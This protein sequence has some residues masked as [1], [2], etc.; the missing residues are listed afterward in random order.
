MVETMHEGTQCMLMRAGTSKGAFFTAEDLPRDP[1][2]RDDLLLRIMG[3][4]D[5]RQIDGIGSG[6]PQTSKV[7]VISPSTDTRAD[8]D[9]LFLQVAVDQ[10]K[11]TSR[12]NCG[13]VL[14]GVGPFAVER[15]LVVPTEDDVTIRIRMVNSGSF[16]K[17]RFAAPN[18]K[19]RYEGNHAIDSVPGTAAPVT[20][21]FEDTAGSTTGALLPTGNAIDTAAG[22]QVTCVDNGMPV[23][24]VKAEDLGITGQETPEDLEANYA[25]GQRLAKIRASAATKMGMGNISGTTVP[26]LALLSPAHSGGSINTRSFIPTTCHTSIGVLA[27]MTV[28][29]GVSIPGAVGYNMV[30]RSDP[31]QAL[32]I[33]H[34]TGQLTVAAAVVD[35]DGCLTTSSSSVIRTTRKLFDGTAFPRARQ[36]EI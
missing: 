34:P 35:H 29:A 32:S 14:V 26:K 1:V 28:A 21:E 8:V 7:A 20:I 27:A 31:N 33:E 24:L 9:Y 10:A 18:G 12:Q 15:G 6:H 16:A 3:S 30:R 25:L 23:V 36:G 19:V 22:V 2:E 11:V 4:P 13:N 5:P 17:A